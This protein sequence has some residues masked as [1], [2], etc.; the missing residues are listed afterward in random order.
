MSVS[1]PEPVRA[2][3]PSPGA[4]RNCEVLAPP[5]RCDLPPGAA[6]HLRFGMR[7]PW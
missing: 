4:M 6:H 1:W 7:A 2:E 5:W 3:E